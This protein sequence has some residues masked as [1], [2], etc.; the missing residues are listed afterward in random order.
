MFLL[1]AHIDL[2]P[3]ETVD[4]NISK[5]TFSTDLINHQVLSPCSLTPKLGYIGVP[6]FIELLLLL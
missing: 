1:R 3:H 5:G 4:R 2:V 6:H